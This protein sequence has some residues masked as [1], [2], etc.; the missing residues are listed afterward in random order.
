MDRCDVCNHDRLRDCEG[1][2]GLGQD[3]S[4]RISGKAVSKKLTRRDIGS[5]V[6]RKRTLPE[7]CGR[8]D[9][10]KWC[11]RWLAGLLCPP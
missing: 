3:R 11:Y 6:L 9:R 2:A 4:T 1:V 5:S 7:G 10:E 8:I